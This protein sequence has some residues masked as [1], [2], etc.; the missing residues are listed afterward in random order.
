MYSAGT[1]ENS[2]VSA[3]KKWL[4]LAALTCKWQLKLRIFASAIASSIF[5]FNPLK[6]AQGRT[7][8]SGAR[9]SNVE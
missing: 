3:S 4:T 9:N 7:G 8:R 2:R 5:N 6:A 1:Y